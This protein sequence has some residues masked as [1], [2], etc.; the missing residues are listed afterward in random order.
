[1]RRYSNLCRLDR[2]TAIATLHFHSD[3]YRQFQT[4][5]QN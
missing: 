3:A 2:A 5:A 1:M 4:T